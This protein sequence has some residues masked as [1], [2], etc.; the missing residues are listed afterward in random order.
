[1]TDSIAPPDTT[2]FGDPDRPKRIFK[3]IVI[4][5]SHVGKTCL[6]YRF[7]SGKFPEKTEATIGVD[8]REKTLEIDDEVFKLQIWDTAGQGT[9]LQSICRHFQME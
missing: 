3:I 7:C 2:V 9:L 5:D 8:F 1:M 6:T 4:G